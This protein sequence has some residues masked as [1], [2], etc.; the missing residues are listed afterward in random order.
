MKRQSTDEPLTPD[1][2]AERLDKALVR[3]LR[4]MYEVRTREGSLL[5]DVRQS[6]YLGPAINHV[7]YELNHADWNVSAFPMKDGD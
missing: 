1:D 6:R 4:I 2:V 3:V 5:A 7:A